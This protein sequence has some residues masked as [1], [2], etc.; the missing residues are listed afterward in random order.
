MSGQTEDHHTIFSPQM[1]LLYTDLF[2]IIRPMQPPHTSP[3]QTYTHP[4]T[5]HLKEM[6]KLLRTAK[7]FP[8]KDNGE[9]KKA[10]IEKEVIF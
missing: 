5:E 4:L 8:V 6:Q 3:S 7:W 1:C 9:K 10:L 2:Y